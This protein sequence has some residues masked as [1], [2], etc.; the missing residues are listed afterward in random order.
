MA[1][2]LSGPGAWVLWVTSRLFRK[3]VDAPQPADEVCEG[4]EPLPE[5]ADR[6]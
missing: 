3:R 1:V 4:A 5:A 2:M 6:A